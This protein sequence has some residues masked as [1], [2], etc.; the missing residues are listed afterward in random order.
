[1]ALRRTGRPPLAGP[2]SQ[3]RAGRLLSPKHRGTS[4]A[5]P[6]A[7]VATLRRRGPWRARG[8]LSCNTGGSAR[9]TGAFPR[10]RWAC[11]PSRGPMP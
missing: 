5:R 8:R 7:L 11:P 2:T 4:K 1:M 10:R 9:P 3:P 6:G